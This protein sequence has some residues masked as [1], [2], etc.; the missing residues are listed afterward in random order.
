MRFTLLILT[1]NEIEGVKIILPQIKKYFTEEIIIIDGG[2][3]DGTLEYLQKNKFKYFI[4]DKPGLGPAYKMGIKNS[5]GDTIILFSPDG[6]S[7]VSRLPELILLM[8]NENADIGI[9][10]RYKD[11]A[12]SDDDDWITSFGNW[13]FTQL[14]NLLYK[15]KVTDLLVIY[16][17]FKKNLVNELNIEHDGISWTTKM[18]CRAAKS[19][20]KIR[21]IPGNEPKRIG[22]VRKMNPIKNGFAELIMIIKEFQRKN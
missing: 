14:Y 7:E 6:N 20:K 4:Q 21:E 12:S 18:M 11:W 17:A 3:T 2:S 19:K 15:Q 13:M 16:R 10:S 5:S 8:K 9:V 22:G 1:L